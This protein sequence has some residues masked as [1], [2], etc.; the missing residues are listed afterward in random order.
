MAI[1][2]PVICACACVLNLPQGEVQPSIKYVNQ[3]AYIKK[4]REF[5]K[6]YGYFV[7]RFLFLFLE[8]AGISVNCYLS[9][10][11]LN[12][13]NVC[14]EGSIERDWVHEETV[15]LSDKM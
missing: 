6:L 14:D 4:Q 13:R 7:C 2:F 5:S 1:L 11:L 3:T 15:I 10:K 9:C 12:L 8:T